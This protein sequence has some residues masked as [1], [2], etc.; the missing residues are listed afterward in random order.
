[1]RVLTASGIF[2]ELAEGKYGNTAVSDSMIDASPLR[3]AFCL[4]FGR[5]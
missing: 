3:D 5:L 1:M 2:E 4:M